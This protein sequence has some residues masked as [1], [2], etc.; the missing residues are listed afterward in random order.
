MLRQPEKHCA[1]GE[2]HFWLDESIKLPSW[3][4]RYA[5]AVVWDDEHRIHEKGDLGCAYKCIHRKTKPRIGTSTSNEPYSLQT[6]WHHRHKN[7]WNHLKS[8]TGRVSWNRV[9]DKDL[10]LSKL[11]RQDWPRPSLT[12]KQKTFFGEDAGTGKLI[13]IKKEWQHEVVEHC[14]ETSINWYGVRDTGSRC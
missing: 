4:L 11:L 5:N 12:K 9:G 1:S 13:S 3:A 8:K 10:L 7:L 14:A 2:G 6:D